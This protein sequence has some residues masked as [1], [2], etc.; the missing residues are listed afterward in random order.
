MSNQWSLLN[1]NYTT[2]RLIG[3]QNLKVFRFYLFIAQ[4]ET[5]LCSERVMGSGHVS[6]QE[7]EGSGLSGLLPQSKG[8]TEVRH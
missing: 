1:L 6:A 3:S 5:L 8:G 4:N 7:L 2:D